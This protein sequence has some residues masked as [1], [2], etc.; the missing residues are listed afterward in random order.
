MKDSSIEYSSEEKD[1]ILIF[2]INENRVDSFKS[3]AFKTELLKL[4]AA[5]NSRILIDLS[6]VDTMDSSGLGA[7]T[8]GRRQIEEVGGELVICGLQEKV[9]TLFNIAKLDSIFKLFS[10]TD[11][12]MEALK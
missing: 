2:K 3:P 7:L 8:F 5:G 6:D 9:Q 1:G 11:E 4:I 12:G 10:T